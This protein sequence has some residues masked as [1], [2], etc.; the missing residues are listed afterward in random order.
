[1]KRLLLIPLFLLL[2]RPA[3]AEAPI[4]VGIE[5]VLALDSSASV[6]R[7]EFQLQL[8]GL[9]LAFRDPD[10]LRQIET[11]KPLGAAIAVIQ[12]GGP[13]ETRIVIPFTHIETA[14]DAK[15][16]GF[17]ISLIRRW[18]RASSTSIATGLEDARALLEGNAFEGHRRVI[19]VSGDG[20]DNSG[21]DIE[22]ARKRIAAADITVNGLPI[23]ADDPTLADYYRDRVIVGATSFIEPAR[24]FDDYV[25]AIKEKLLRE[26]RPLES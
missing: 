11:L 9:A 18:M 26:L 14:R 2:A 16:L 6:D 4:A 10:V 5:L 21:V 15:A 8:D 13:G 17:H 3:P 22:E 24:D 7:Q 19:D 23:L 25:R 20:P 1:M 12:W